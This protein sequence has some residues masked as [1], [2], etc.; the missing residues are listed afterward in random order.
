[1]SG[2]FEGVRVLE[3]AQWVFV[4]AAGA[5]MADQG[6]D[7]IKIENP[8]TGDPYRGLMT[9]GIGAAP[10]RGSTSTGE[11]NNRGKRSVA[12]DI[13]TEQGRE[14]MYKLIEGSDVFLTN[15]RPEALARLGY[16]VEDLRAHNPTAHLRPGSRLRHPRPRGQH[17]ELRQHRLL[18]PGWLRPHSDPVRLSGA[19]SDRGVRSATSR[20][21]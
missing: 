15:F 4:P 17:P 3:L 8:A 7:V 13:R 1:M 5:V 16:G 9:Q 11:Q 21:R 18:G 10:S 2:M 14:L 6:A 20:R 12:L 19:R